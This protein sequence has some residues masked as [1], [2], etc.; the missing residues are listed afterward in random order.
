MIWKHNEAAVEEL[1]STQSVGFVAKKKINWFLCLW[2]LQSY[3]FLSLFTETQE[4]R[5]NDIKSDILTLKPFVLLTVDYII[6]F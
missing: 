1:V 5:V 6:V 2:G 4:L 3:S